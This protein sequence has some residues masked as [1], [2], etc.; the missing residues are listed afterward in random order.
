M[1]L[2]ARGACS[3]NPFGMSKTS[4]FLSP[5]GLHIRQGGDCCVWLI[6]SSGL[7]VGYG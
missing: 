2:D 5:K 7:I 6:C 3:P 1:L 4:G